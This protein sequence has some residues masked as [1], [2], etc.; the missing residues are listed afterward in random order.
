MDT[1][2]R[3]PTAAHDRPGGRPPSPWSGSHHE[4]LLRW[5]LEQ[6]RSLD[7]AART[8]RAVAA[9]LAD[10]HR[11]GW[12]LEEPVARGRLVAARASRRTRAAAPPRARRDRPTAPSA[13][14]LAAAGGRR[15]P[16]RRRRGPAPRSRRA[17][18]DPGRGPRRGDWAQVGGPALAPGER[19]ALRRPARGP[20][21][22]RAHAGRSPAP[23]SARCSTWSRTGRRCGCTPCGTAGSCA[24][25]RRC[26]SSTPR[27]AAAT[28]ADAAAAFLRLAGAVEASARAGGRLDGTDD[29]LLH[30]V[31]PG[32]DAPPAVRVTRPPCPGTLRDRRLLFGNLRRRNQGAPVREPLTSPVAR[33]RDA[34]ATRGA[35]RR[36]P[37]AARSTPRSCAAC[38]TVV[39][40]PCARRC[41][42]PSGPTGS[43]PGPHAGRRGAPGVGHRDDARA[44]AGA[45]PD[46]RL[47][48]GLRRV[49]RGRRVRRRVR[50]ARPRRPV[51]DGQGRGAVGP[52][53]RGGAGARARRPTTTATCPRS[54]TSRCP[55]ASP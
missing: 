31:Y 18:A 54:W 50:D 55:A 14:A 35:P 7:E 10:A 2:R 24:R 33:R 16:A 47:P 15:A 41:V 37:P 30:V 5:Q 20:G 29:G 12:W 38:S 53:R 52:V 1:T 11:A 9:V 36:A 49:G 45:A 17:R 34:K 32:P 8:L 44:G 13:P 22:R 21:R 4:E 27:T 3:T 40:T 6:V 28:L 46:P 48:A 39:T 51:A 43:R 23:G 19:E 42:P 25:S 26:R